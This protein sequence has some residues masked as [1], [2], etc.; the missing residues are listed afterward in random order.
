MVVHLFIPKVIR[1]DLAQSLTFFNNLFKFPLVGA[2]S[3]ISSV[4]KPPQQRELPIE[5]TLNL[6]TK[7]EMEYI[8]IKLCFIV[9]LF[10]KN[11]SKFIKH[12]LLY[13]FYNHF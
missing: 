11:Y 7:I 12:V 13:E 10:H 4:N 2:Q 3:K 8:V 1:L 5:T 6:D 9:L